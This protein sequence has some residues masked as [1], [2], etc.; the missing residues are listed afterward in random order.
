MPTG[1]TLPVSTRP[2]ASGDTF[3]Y[4]GS[5]LET[6]LYRGAS[7]NP[8]GTIAYTITQHVTDEGTAPFD[9][10]NPYDLRTVETDQ[11]TNQTITVTTDTYYNTG[12]F[13]TTQSA[14][15]TYGYSSSD[16][17]GQQISDTLASVGYNGGAPNG[18]IDILPEA[19][20]QHWTNT[21]AATLTESE[22]DGFRADRTT[23][24]D[25]TYS[26]T[27]SY[28]QG[29]QFTPAPSP[30]PATLS[31]NADGSGTYSL[32]LFGVTPNTTIT[33]SAPSSGTITIAVSGVA[34]YTVGT[35][36]SLPLYVENDYQ[37]GEMSIPAACNVPSGFGTFANAIQQG[38]TKVD[39]VLGTTEF[40]TEITYVVG[41]YAVCVS[42]SDVDYVYYDYSGQGN[43][44]PLGASFSG[45][46]SP[47]E[48]ITLNSTVGLSATNVAGAARRRTLQAGSER[49]A[50]AR[51]NFQSTLER[52]RLERRHQAFL[53]LRA[54][55]LERSH[56]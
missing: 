22:S 45:G 6:L 2:L 14:F 8:S 23:N 28:P 1:T 50:F 16:T 24:A 48:V 37:L 44:A 54:R 51:T 31:D 42:L 29:S 56:R 46:Q 17:N 43:E 7:P 12:P 25:G 38:Y 27:D 26:E 34:T 15:Y 41:G 35:W 39:T 9:G 5:S 53:R 3:T 40:Y 10:A 30:L 49:V 11:G 55:F 47:L 19:A 4:G 18:L 20:Q 32:P 21:G 36:Y 52:R 13:G 33:Y